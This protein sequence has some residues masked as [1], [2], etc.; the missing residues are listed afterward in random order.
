MICGLV[1][2]SNIVKFLILHLIEY[3]EWSIDNYY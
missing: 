1:L 3:G 2:N